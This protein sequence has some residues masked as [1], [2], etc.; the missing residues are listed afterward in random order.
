LWLVDDDDR[1]KTMLCQTEFVLKVMTLGVHSTKR[2]LSH[3]EELEE[4]SEQSR[5]SLPKSHI[6]H[7]PLQDH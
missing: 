4:A 2:K 1:M 6:H 3:D 5:R 7:L